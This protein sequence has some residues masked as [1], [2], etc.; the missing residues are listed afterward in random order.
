MSLNLAY[1]LERAREAREQADAATLE[2]VRDTCLRSLKAW[3]EMADRARKVQRARQSREAVA[4]FVRSG[5]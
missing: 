1:C 4:T 2:N 3:E 5:E